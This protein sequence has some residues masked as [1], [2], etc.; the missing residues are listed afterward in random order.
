[1]EDFSRFYVDEFWRKCG[2][3]DRVSNYSEIHY[4]RNI[5]ENWVFL[6]DIFEN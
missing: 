2:Q 4:G 3:G 1:V 5:I 6:K